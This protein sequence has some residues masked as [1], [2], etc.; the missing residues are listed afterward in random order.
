MSKAE[1]VLRVNKDKIY[2]L[3]PYIQGTSIGIEINDDELEEEL[4]AF[5]RRLKALFVHGEKSVDPP[6]KEREIFIFVYIQDG[7]DSTLIPSEIDGVR[8]K[9]KQYQ[10]LVCE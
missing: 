1:D 3:S 8:I 6:K 7:C 2:A 4:S 5:E 10:E 9:V